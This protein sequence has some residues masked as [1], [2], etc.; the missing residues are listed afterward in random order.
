MSSRVPAAPQAIDAVG[1]QTKKIFIAGMSVNL[2]NCHNAAGFTNF[3]N[4]ANG[5]EWGRPGALSC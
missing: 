3:H 4:F 5:A 2:G 1:D